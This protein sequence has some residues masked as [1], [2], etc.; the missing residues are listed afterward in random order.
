[1]GKAG[2]AELR[3]G[4]LNQ[5]CPLLNEIGREARALEEVSAVEALGLVTVDTGLVLP[6]ARHAAEAVVSKLKGSLGKM[7]GM[8][9]GE[10]RLTQVL[11]AVV[12]LGGGGVVGVIACI[13]V[14]GSP[15]KDSLLHC[16]PPLV[17]LQVIDVLQLQALVAEDH[18]SEPLDGLEVGQGGEVLAEPRSAAQL[19]EVVNMSLYP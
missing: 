19:P 16:S 4:T 2:E 18:R 11:E 10:V 8:D 3:V 15:L 13:V 14:G 5:L 9:I 7:D 1:M 6:R 12:P 17:V